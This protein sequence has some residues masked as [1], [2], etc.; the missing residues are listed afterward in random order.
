MRDGFVYI[1]ASITRTLYIGV[2]NGLERRAW[3]HQ[4]GEL[5]GFTKRYDLK[6]LV[7]FEYYE[8]IR[9]AITREK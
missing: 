7:Y 3:R 1:M 4:H 8:D 6:R 5:P 9:D 2:T